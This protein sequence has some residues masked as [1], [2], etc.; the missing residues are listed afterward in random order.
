MQRP[1]FFEALE[2]HIYALLAA[3]GRDLETVKSDAFL[4]ADH[5]LEGSQQFVAQAFAG[6][7]EDVPVGLAGGRFE[8]F[9]GV[10]ADVEDVALVIDEN[11]WRGVALQDQLIR[12]GLE[13]ERRLRRQP[14]LRIRWAGPAL[15]EEGNSIG[16]GRTMDSVR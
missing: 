5:F 2:G 3:I 16:S 14:C 13:A 10:A 4:L 15:K 12:E 1:G 8:V 6:H 7:D 11:G 9:A